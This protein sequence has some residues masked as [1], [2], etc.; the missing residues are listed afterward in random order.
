MTIDLSRRKIIAALGGATA[1]WPLT[2]R[3]QQVAIPTIGYLGSGSPNEPYLAA[4]LRGL[5]EGGLIEHQSIVIE[6][7]WANGHYEQLPA[8]ASDL[9][10]RGVTAIFTDGGSA[11]A[12]AAKQATATIPIV[13]VNGDDPIK[14]GLVS[15]ISRPEANVTGVTSYSAALGS[16]KLELLRELVPRSGVVGVM[17]NR[18]NSSSEAEVANVTAAAKVVGQELLVLE[19]SSEG[20][21]EDAF[22][23]LAHEKVIALLVTTGVFL[24]DHKERIV[25]LASGYALP[26]IYD[27]REFAALGGLMSYGT[28]FPD[29]F[30]QG[31]I[32]I[33]RILKGARPADLP[34]LQPTTFE[35]VINLKTAKALG[36]T[37]PPTLLVAADEVIE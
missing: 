10:G 23:T 1:M 22:K 4:F 27:R 9:A 35:L 37:A 25:A 33:A 11:P 32:Y 7:R 36:L 17:M 28:R 31:G 26:A 16:K 29:V 19:V 14:S 6:Y 15:S 3:A 21:I 24:G 5:N 13:F 34:I 8:L 20:D 2:V 18:G 12:H 30:R